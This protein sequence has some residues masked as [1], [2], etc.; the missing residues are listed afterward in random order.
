MAGEG[1]LGDRI[2]AYRERLELTTEAL[3]EKSGVGAAVLAAVEAGDVYPALG[4]LVKIARAL[5]QRLGTFMDDQYRADPIIMRAGERAS[6]RISHKAGASGGFEYFPL[7]RG[8]TDRHME[9]F[10][11]EIAKDAAR[12]VSSHEGEEFIAVVSGEVELEY[13]DAT[14]TL[15]AGDTAYYNSVVPHILK[16]GGGEPAGIYAIVFTPF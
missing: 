4:V 15:H 2:R 8:K 12:Q 9:P 13:G 6:E 5:G 16:A 11:I 14:T 7:G 10:Y 1:K 3:A